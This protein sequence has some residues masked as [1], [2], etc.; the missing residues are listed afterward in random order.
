[1]TGMFILFPKGGKHRKLPRRVR[2]VPVTE[3]FQLPLA[4][5]TSVILATVLSSVKWP[6]SPVNIKEATK[7]AKVY[8][9]RSLILHI[10]CFMLID[11]T[12]IT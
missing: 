8:V 1:M 3:N 6:R 10:F 9:G 4:S 5:S 2:F 7:Q 12:L 11:Y